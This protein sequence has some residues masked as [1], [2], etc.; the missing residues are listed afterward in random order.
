MKAVAAPWHA[1]L[2][3]P[4]ERVGL[5]RSSAD[6]RSRLFTRADSINNERAAGCEFFV[7]NPLM[8]GATNFKLDSVAVLR[9]FLIEF[10][11]K[12]LKAQE[13]LVEGKLKLPFTTKTFSGSRSYHYVISLTEPL[14][15]LTDY[16]LVTELLMRVVGSDMDS[17]CRNANRLT[18]LPGAVRSDKNGAVQTLMEVRER[19]RLDDLLRWAANVKPRAYN[20]WIIETEPRPRRQGAIQDEETEGL[21]YTATKLLDKGEYDE[22]IGR[23]AALVKLAVELVYKNYPIDKVEELLYDGQDKLAL[24]RDDVPGIIK[25]VERRILV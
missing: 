23:H 2:F 1:A 24:E 11:K 17:Q 25:W 8:P 19:V 5:A 4:Y 14:E 21:S 22:R 7:L 20:E 13:E 10:D 9:N 6:V 16:W 12:T 3:E 18:R 15:S